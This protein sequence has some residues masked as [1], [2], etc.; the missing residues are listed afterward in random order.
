MVRDLGVVEARP[1]PL[2]M[3]QPPSKGQ[4]IKISLEGLPRV[5][6]TTTPGQTTVVSAPQ[7]HGMVWPPPSW[8]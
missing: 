8:P 7:G 1:W 3:V 6:E 5:A 2:G 4:P